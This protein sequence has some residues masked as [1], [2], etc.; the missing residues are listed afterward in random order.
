MKFIR[1]EERHT[2]ALEQVAET[3]PG[4]QVWFDF[5]RHS[6]GLQ[7]AVYDRE[8]D[9]RYPVYFCSL[10]N[11]LYGKVV[12]MTREIMH[13]PGLTQEQSERNLESGEL[14]PGYIAENGRH[15]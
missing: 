5:I 13:V 2:E 11:D 8:R 1:N 12:T 3:Y 15:D 6:G 14:P 4:L 7:L 9:P 10:S